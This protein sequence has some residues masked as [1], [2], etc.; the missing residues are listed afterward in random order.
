VGPSACAW[1]AKMDKRQKFSVDKA[2]A[3]EKGKGDEP[4]QNTV[5][6]K[7]FI[8]TGE[9]L[10]GG[11]GRRS[12]LTRNHCD[13]ALSLCDHAGEQPRPEQT[14]DKGTSNTKLYPGLNQPRLVATDNVVLGEDK[15]KMRKEN[16]HQQQALHAAQPIT[17]S[18]TQY[19][20]K[21]TSETPTDHSTCP[22][23]RNSMFPMGRALQHPAAK[24]LKDWAT[25]GCPT[26]TGKQWSKTEIWKAV[27][28][29]PHCSAL[30]PEAIKHFAVEAAEKVRTKQA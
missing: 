23:H 7:Q 20:G 16:K 3:K 5:D 12:G 26:K 2:E 24:L 14:N 15:A 28:R 22:P 17:S 19:Q 6:D 18:W 13:N 27:E 29:G 21:M 10:Y 4:P 1:A 8:L 30:S 25:V 9:P 11:K